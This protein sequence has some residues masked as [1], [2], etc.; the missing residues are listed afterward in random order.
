MTRVNLKTILL[1]AIPVAG[2][3][4]IGA[5]LLLRSDPA[6]LERGKRDR[7]ELQ[8]MVEEERKTRAEDPAT[9]V[10]ILRAGAQ[11]GAD[12]KEAR[13]AILR[14]GERSVPLL[15][16]TALDPK[17]PASLRQEAIALL[18]DL[19][20]APADEAILDLLRSPALEEPHRSLILAKLGGRSIEG[21]FAILKKIYEEET[22]F[23][24]R[25]LLLKAIGETR[26]PD[27]TPLLLDALR[28][29]SAAGARIQALDSLGGRSSEPGVL[30][31]LTEALRTDRD[32]NVR[33]AAVAALGPC[34]DPSVDQVLRETAEGS[35]HPDAVRKAAASWI[36]RRKKP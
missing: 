30:P 27:A 14:H 35:G 11:G 7:R 17:E 16:E 23:P 25:P 6:F 29:E 34:R 18:M 8:S 31:R 3:V 10:Q 15:R 4:G 33:L 1:A 20:I 19:R 32:E 12:P 9:A 24:Q 26:S 5:A 13:A 22:G 21:S 2:V 36:G 28:R